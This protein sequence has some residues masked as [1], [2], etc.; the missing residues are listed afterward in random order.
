MLEEDFVLEVTHKMATIVYTF[1]AGNL[2]IAYGNDL[3]VSHCHFNQ[4]NPDWLDVLMFFIRGHS[5]K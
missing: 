3:S 2:A 4:I 5:S 1:F